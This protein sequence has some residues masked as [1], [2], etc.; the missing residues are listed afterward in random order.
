MTKVYK[1]Y[2]EFKKED[3][4][5]LV[6]FDGTHEVNPHDD[7]FD[8]FFEKLYKQEEYYSYLEGIED[9]P[10]KSYTSSQYRKMGEKIYV[11]HYFS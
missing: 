1:Y 9:F 7:E 3:N 6:I 5:K 11:Q 4:F 8:F 2:K 10:F